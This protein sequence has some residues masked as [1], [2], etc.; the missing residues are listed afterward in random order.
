MEWVSYLAYLVIGLLSL[1]SL[2][3]P[4]AFAFFLIN[5]IGVILFMGG[6]GS[7]SQLMLS[8][9]D[10]LATFVLSP[11]PM[12]I[13]MGE[14]LYHS[15]MAYNAMEVFDRM[16]GKLPGRLYLLGVLGGTVFAAMTGSGMANAAMLG[17]TLVPEMTNRGYDKK[18]SLGSIIGSGGLAIMIPPS[19]LAVIL[20]SLAY[21]P[22][23]KILIGGIMPGLLMAALFATYIIIRCKLN[24]SLAPYYEFAP[25][26]LSQKIIGFL[27]YVLP[28]GSV[29]FLV[30]GTMILGA[31]TPNES[32]ALGA[33]GSFILGVIYGGLNK[34]TMKNAIVGTFRINVMVLTIIAMASGYSQL[35]G[36][37][38][39][40]R[41]VVEWILS[42][43]MPPT[44][45]LIGMNII[46][47]ILGCLM[48]QVCIMIITIPLFM[49][50]IK[51]MGV[52][53]LWFGIQF[54]INMEIAVASPPFGLILFV[55]KGVAPEGTTMTDIYKAAIPFVLLEVL[56]LTLVIIFP[57][58]GLWLPSFMK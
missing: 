30:I 42:L 58:I 6:P 35:M 38:G 43:K 2:G 13:L 54:L 26:P 47:L 34:Q 37:T 31:A 15:K 41:G 24:P 33:F 52:N 48:E 21:I 19:S 46:L 8:I 56:A 45:V 40:A 17:S 16:T 9:Y 57:I 44:L 11:V 3:M 7:L 27:K 50:I 36:F 39:A 28:L 14:I 22:I 10:S 1:F 29:I 20:G 49:P 4:I 53:E 5:V 23:A 25:T 12:F 51:A 55:M 18:L 32:A